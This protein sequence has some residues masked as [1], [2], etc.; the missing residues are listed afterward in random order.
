MLILVQS[1]KA[2]SGCDVGISALTTKIDWLENHLCN[3]EYVDQKQ[4][5][6]KIPFCRPRWYV[7][8][9]VNT[10][11]NE[12]GSW[13]KYRQIIDPVK[14]CQIRLS[15]CKIKNM[16]RVERLINIRFHRESCS[17]W[18]ADISSLHN[19]L[20]IQWDLLRLVR[21]WVFILLFLLELFYM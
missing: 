2:T 13:P 7:L 15:I 20:S 8:L 5:R 9:L 4:K 12:S 16:G 21:L 10:K 19:N 18:F 1:F 3:L 17:T 6:T 11:Q 14:Y